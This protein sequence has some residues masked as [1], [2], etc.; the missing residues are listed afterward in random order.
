ML[1]AE[2]R[3]PGLE[4]VHALEEADYLA[5]PGIRR[6]PVPEFRHE[7]WCVGFDDRMEP[8]ANDAVRFRH[9]SDCRE[10]GGFSFCGGRVRGGR[11]STA[12]F[13]SINGL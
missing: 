12:I 7:V 9:R 6:H 5:V 1:E 11:L 3:V 8:F 10:H 2:R 13:P 4:F